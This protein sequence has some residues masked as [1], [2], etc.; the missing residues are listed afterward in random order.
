MRVT[1]EPLHPGERNRGVRIDNRDDSR[2]A[3]PGTVQGP[4]R[5]DCLSGENCLGI[6]P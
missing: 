2:D 3:R 4:S 5:S 6:G 1:D